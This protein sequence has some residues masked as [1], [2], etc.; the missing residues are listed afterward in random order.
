MN[1]MNPILAFAVFVP[2]SFWGLRMAADWLNLQSAKKGVIP[3][4]FQESGPRDSIPYLVAQTHFGWVHSGVELGG[5]VLFLL[6]GGFGLIDEWARGFGRGDIL[7]GLLFAGVIALLGFFL[8]LPFSLWHTFRLE[9]RFGFNRT[10]VRTWILDRVKGLLLGTILG[11]GIFAALIWFFQEAGGNAWWIAWLFLVTVQLILMVI[12]PVWL[13]PLFNK[14]TPLPEGELRQAIEAYAKKEGFQLGGIF[15]MDGSKR[16]SKANAFFT[17]FGRTRRIALF[18]TLLEK[19]TKEE[20]VAVLAHEV[21]HS[22]CSHVPKMFAISSL[23]SLLLFKGADFLLSF[24]GMYRAFQVDQASIYSG[25]VI[26]GVLFGPIQE[27]MGVAMSAL[28]RKHEFEADAFARKTTGSGVAL[29]SALK[30]LAVE[31]LANLNPHPLKVFLEYSHPPVT[32]RLRA[33]RG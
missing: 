6:F 21:G 25:L 23:S 10:T 1:S 31:N 22:K 26:L 4:E 3:P 28:S 19:T 2:I 15:T 17:G 11:G 8:G 20:V 5:S 29:S 33:L 27:V 30:K 24:D 7:T 12:A 32:E 14:F 16:S 9:E 18:D 13:L